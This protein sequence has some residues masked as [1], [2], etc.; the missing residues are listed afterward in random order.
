MALGAAAAG[1]VIGIALTWKW[2]LQTGANVDFSPS[3]HWPDP[4]TS[5]PVEA[6]RGPVLVL[7]EYHIDPSNR[8]KFLRALGRVAR[9]RRRDGA[10]DWGVFEDPAVEGRFIETFQSDSWNEHL[11]QHRRVTNADRVLEQAARVFQVGEGPKTTH[12]ISALRDSQEP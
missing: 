8:E 12:L 2:K 7:I 11:R 1:A 9:E 10:F 6:D 3:M 4:V 5:G